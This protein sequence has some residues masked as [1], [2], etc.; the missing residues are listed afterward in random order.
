MLQEAKERIKWLKKKPD[1]INVANY[2]SMVL[3][4]HSYYCVATDVTKDFYE[5]AYKLIKTLEIGM[6]RA[7]ASSK[8][9]KDKTYLKFYKDYKGKEYYISQKALYP[10]RYIQTKPPPMYNQKIND[11]TQEGRA[12]IHKRQELVS[13]YELMYL[14]QNP[15]INES[16]EYNDNRISK[17]V[18]QK[19]KC[20]VTKA[21]LKP[22]EIHCYHIKPRSLEGTD[23]YSNLL[24]VCNDVHKL[25]HA[26]KQETIQ[27]YLNKLSLNKTQIAKLNELRV[28]AGNQAI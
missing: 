2:N 8:G 11:Y 17:Y 7:S 24:I 22:W 15:V 13:S 3:G 5:I 28:K 9:Y 20:A 25:I 10:I 12:L 27:D 26:T 19:G 1:T 23:V 4:V 21:R 6:R 14:V 16:I 18:A